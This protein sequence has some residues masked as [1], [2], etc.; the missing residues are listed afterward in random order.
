MNEALKQILEQTGAEFMP[1]GPPDA[2]VEIA[3]SFDVYE[4]E[5]AAFRSRVALMHWPQRA[6][7]QFTG[8][9]VKDYLNR[10]LTQ[11]IAKLTGGDST[12][13]LLLTDKGRVLSDLFVHFGD[14]S[15]WLEMD[16][17][18]LQAVRDLLEGRLFTEDV[19]IEDITADRELL[20]LYG[21][22][23]MAVLEHLQNQSD[24]S[25]GYFELLR[26]PGLPQGTSKH[27]VLELAGSRVSVYRRD[28]G[29]VTGLQL[30]VKAADAANLW[31]ALIEL[32]G[33]DPDH[34]KD[35]AFAEQRREGF[36]GRPAGWL[37]FNTLRVEAG[38]P[39]FHIDYGL[40]SLPAETGW[41]EQTC[42]FTKGCYVG[43]EVVA[44]MKNLGHPKQVIMG[45]EFQ[46]D[47]LPAAGEQV[48]NIKKTDEGE[49][50]A[51]AIGVI[52]SSTV[53]PMQGG[54]ARALATLKWGF[55]E[56]GTTLHTHAEGKLV[57]TTV[58]DL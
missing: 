57:E 29:D 15:T 35:A 13:S 10:M 12:H 53:S 14:A 37:A 32:V 27:V 46:G 18:D 5:Y 56:P 50:T 44:R 24:N 47:A 22:A 16:C 2:G 28:I 48:L 6:L 4:A 36:R 21:P 26:E 41:L 54:Q 38:E 40:E 17:F 39:W 42:S 7:L 1:Y 23:A 11:D 52:T 43:Q 8:T 49:S 51:K 9:D 30:W 19:T 25:H 20:A 34:E 45:L 31:S 58:S 33:F 55:H 3:A